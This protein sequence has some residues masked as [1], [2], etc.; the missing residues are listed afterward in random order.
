MLRFDPR[1][2]D[3]RGWRLV[4]LVAELRGIPECELLQ[5]D[6]GQADVALARQIAMY[7]MH[8]C[9]GRHYAEVGRFF[10]RDRTT[11]SHACALIEEMRENARF[12]ATLQWVESELAAE[13]ACEREAT[14]AA[15]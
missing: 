11:V 10:G 9:Y 14:H 13:A 5:R 8:T 15:A 2:A 4:D 3:P 1:R 6:R 12:D 7:L